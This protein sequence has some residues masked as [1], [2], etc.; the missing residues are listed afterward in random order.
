MKKEEYI[1]MLLADNE[2]EK[3][4]QKELNEAIIDC[5]DIAL[6]QE[7]EDFEIKD[8]KIGL[9]TFWAAIREAGRKEASHCV[10]PLRAAEL[11]AQKLGAKFERASRRLAEKP[12]EPKVV[13]LEDLF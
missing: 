3:Q 4:P 10:S 7:P 9:D 11:I 12:A 1:R 5:V 6:S 8:T 2:T 13:R